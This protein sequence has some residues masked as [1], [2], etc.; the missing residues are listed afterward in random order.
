MRPAGL[1]P[2]NEASLAVSPSV[3]A[4]AALISHRGRCQ[5]VWSAENLIIRAHAALPS[6]SV[7]THKHP[8]SAP[9]H[10]G[11]AGETALSRGARP[12]GKGHK[13][14]G[15]E[16]PGVRRSEGQGRQED[17]CLG[18]C[19]RIYS[20]GDRGELSPTFWPATRPAHLSATR[21]VGPHWHAPMRRICLL[22]FR[23]GGKVLLCKISGAFFP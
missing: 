18:K 12:V 9:P 10:R 3:L 4:E 23:W 1:G 11:R 22:T 19:L 21:S 6:P 8:P 5:F 14:P 17:A 7:F 2:A 15:I 16:T 20:Q 13:G